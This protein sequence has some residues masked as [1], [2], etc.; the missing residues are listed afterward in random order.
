LSDESGNGE[1]TEPVEP[2]PPAPPQDPPPADLYTPP[3]AEQTYVPPPPPEQTYVPPPPPPAD[4]YTPP[5]PP[6]PAQPPPPP[7]AEQTY[8]PPAPP[9]EPVYAPPPPPPPPPPPD[10]VYTPPLTETAFQAPS[11]PTYEPPPPPPAPPTAPMASPSAGP[12]WASPRARLVLALILL[13]TGIAVFF[14]SGKTKSAGAGE[15]FLEGSDQTGSDT[16][17]PS[18]AAAKPATLAPTAT[19]IP[20]ASSGGLLKTDASKPGLYGGTRDAA[21]CKAD[22]LVTYLEANPDRATPWAGA[23]NIKP[24]DIRA[25]VATLT[26]AVLRVDTRV[27]DFGF[28]AG[29]AVARQSILQ[30]GTAVFLDR[31]AYPRV[32]CESGDPLAEPLAVKSAPQYT[33]PRWP[34]FSPATVVV[35]TPAQQTGA[36]ILIDIT[37][38]LVFARIPGSIV[39]IDIDQPANGVTLVIV[40]P[41]GPARI[42]GANWPPG[43]AV[44]VNF[45]NPATLLATV[46]ADGGG[47][48]AANVTIPATAAAGVH[49]VTMSGGGF[50]VPQP[51]YVIPPAPGP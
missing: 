42:T 6:P 31:T 14:G 10:P 20:Q 26:P 3:P 9:A 28:L 37:N 34:G 25:F 41:G 13:A 49:Q 29:K 36:I 51:V 50:S 30:A 12:W 32:R 17:T 40:E 1:T 43:T 45:D 48:I 5:P 39:I 22:T 38:G 21:S 8:V 33:G 23:L 35:V 11:Q 16:F 4:L 2:D 15:V 27:T 18:L 19:T 44:T 24:A 47:N 7:P 46:T